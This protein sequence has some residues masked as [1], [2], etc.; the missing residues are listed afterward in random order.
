MCVF[1][2]MRLCMGVFMYVI[3]ILSHTSMYLR[4]NTIRKSIL[5]RYINISV[6]KLISY[7]GAGVK[8]NFIHL[9]TIANLIKLDSLK[10]HV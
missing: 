6:Y 3:C 5:H 1:V 2:Y 4:S 10:T 7:H 8:L 9:Q